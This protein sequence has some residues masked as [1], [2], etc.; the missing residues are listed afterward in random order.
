MYCHSCGSEINDKAEICVKCGVRVKNPPVVQQKSPGTALL[1]SLLI[2][3]VGQI[4]N[5]QAT[6]GIIIMIVLIILGI[7]VVGW[8]LIPFLWIYAMY[9]A[10]TQANKIN[11]QI[12]SSPV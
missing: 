11:E 8:L 6:K 1:L 12:A 3:G 9:D 2:M 4:Y 5:G 10:Y 7:S